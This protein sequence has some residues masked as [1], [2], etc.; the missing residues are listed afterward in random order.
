MEHTTWDQT[1]LCVIWILVFGSQ[2]LVNVMHS[3][4]IH[5][6]AHSQLPT[7]VTTIAT[8]FTVHHRFML[9]HMVVRAIIMVPVITTDLVEPKSRSPMALHNAEGRVMDTSACS[10][11][12]MDLN[13]RPGKT[14]PAVLTTNLRLLDNIV[15]EVIA[16]HTSL[17]DHASVSLWTTTQLVVITIMDT[18]MVTDMV[19]DMATD[20]A[21]AVSDVMTTELNM[22]ITKMAPILKRTTT[23]WNP[24][25][26]EMF[27][28]P[29][30][31]ALLDTLR[32]TLYAI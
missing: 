13:Q 31:P 14:S 26:M 17:V 6:Y 23:K 1:E 27:G 8:E 24:K 20:I 11:V 7:T 29:N 16:I 22:L 30:S 25:N 4:V 10:C 5:Q 19:T 12:I 28:S 18:D 21:M 15:S 9:C 2:N 32:L 3:T